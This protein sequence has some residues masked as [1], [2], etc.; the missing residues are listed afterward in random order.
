MHSSLGHLTAGPALA[1]LHFREQATIVVSATYA[2]GRT[3]CI[4]RS[5]GTRAWAIDSL[6]HIQQIYRG[7]VGSRFIRINASMLPKSRYVAKRLE[8]KRPYLVLLQP[9]SEKMKAIKTKEGISF[10]D[11]LREEE[12]IAIV[13]TK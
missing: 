6:F 12:I 4:L 13:E 7:K 10:W 5:D 11:S 8:I 9:G 2:Q 3:P 1:D